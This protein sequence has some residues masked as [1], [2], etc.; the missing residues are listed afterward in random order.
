M[1][2]AGRAGEEHGAG[3]VDHTAGAIDVSDG[4]LVSG[5]EE[6][7]WN[8]GDSNLGLVTHATISG[9]GVMDQGDVMEN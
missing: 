6:A 9:K 1:K 7:G 4:V 3:L 2:G 8:V 5:T